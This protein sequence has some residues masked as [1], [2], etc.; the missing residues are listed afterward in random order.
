MTDIVTEKLQLLP[1]SPGVYLMKNA[2]GKVIYVGKAVV[3]KNRVRQ[4]FQ[5]SRKKWGNIEQMVTQIRR[6]EYIVTDSDLE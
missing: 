6:F 3:L 5:S 2:Q 1:S 4:Y